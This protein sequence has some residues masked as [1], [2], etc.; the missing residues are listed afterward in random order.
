MTNTN[1]LK[2]MKPMLAKI[3][4]GV[5]AQFG[6]NCEVLVHDL[7]KRSSRNTI[8][9]IENGQVTGR[10]V[11]DDA[12][13]I[14]LEAIRKQTVSEHF[15]YI[16]HTSDGRMLKSSTIPLEGPD[17][18][19]I[20][21]FCINY[22]V[23]DLVLANNTLSEFIAASKDGD[24]FDTIVTNVNDMLDGLIQEAHKVIGKPVSKMTKEDKVRAIL[25]LDEKGAL[26]IKKSSE[27]IAKFFGISKYTLY[28]YLEKRADPKNPQED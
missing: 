19:V 15:N 2:A 6:P 17:K 12:S 8:A 7:T 21:L 28:N 26:L 18:T 9:I 3:A 11:G 14:V 23:S 5:A 16:R 4:K 1:E 13:E 27:R 24:D 22:D 20:A 10:K 25:Y